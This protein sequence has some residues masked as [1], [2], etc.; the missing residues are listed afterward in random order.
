MPPGFDDPSIWGPL[1]NLGMVV[2]V[3]L[4]IGGVALLIRR[5]APIRTVPYSSETARKVHEHHTE[6]E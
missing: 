2:V 6:Q 4:V 1:I 3:V 5:L